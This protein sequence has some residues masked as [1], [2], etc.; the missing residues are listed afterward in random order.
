MPVTVE[1]PTLPTPQIP[2]GDTQSNDEILAGNIKS[3]SD[4]NKLLVIILVLLI[5]GI[6]TA[7]AFILKPWEGGFK[8]SELFSSF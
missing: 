7:L 4:I 3:K 5:I 2:K 8:F 6:I 1:K